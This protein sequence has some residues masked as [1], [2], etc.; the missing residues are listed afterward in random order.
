MK[1]IIIVIIVTFTIN[2]ISAQTNTIDTISFIQSKRMSESD[3]TKKKEGTFVT[4]IPDFS[5][6]PVTGFGFG[7]RTN[8]YWNGKREN[9]FLLTLL[10]YEI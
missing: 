1:K 7:V 2:A 9:P 3:L 6:D 10:P 8:V 5:S 4:G